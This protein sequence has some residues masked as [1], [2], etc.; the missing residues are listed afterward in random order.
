VVTASKSTRH[1]TPVPDWWKSR[2]LSAVV[3]N[4]RLNVA[5]E[6]V[7]TTVPTSHYNMKVPWNEIDAYG[8]TNYQS[9]V[10]FCFDAAADAVSAGR[11]ATFDGDILRYNVANIRSLYKSE[12][13]A[14]DI[15]NIISWQSPD[16]PRELHFSIQKDDGTLLFQS[17]MHFYPLT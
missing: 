1:P 14:N 12:S 16:D 4:E 5:A 10:R 9:Y 2:Y 6:D 3:G 17:C 8:H 15:L 13:R 11:Y 7:P